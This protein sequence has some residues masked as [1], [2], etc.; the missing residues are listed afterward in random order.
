VIILDSSAVL[1]LLKNEKGADQ[2][3]AELG[4]A[5]ISTANVAEVYGCASTFSISLNAI[6]LLI[7]SHGLQVIPLSLE[8]AKCAGAMIEITSF[9]GLS[10]GDRCCLALA[11]DMMHP[12]MTADRA[13]SKIADLLNLEIRLIR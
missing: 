13:W 8:H 2:V 10:L 4:N 12:V 3:E 11:T 5:A 7:A 9:A 6:D 1:A